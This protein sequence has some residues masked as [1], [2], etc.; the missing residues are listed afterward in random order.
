MD[1]KGLRTPGP[2]I[3]GYNALEWLPRLL[4]LQDSGELALLLKPRQYIGDGSSRALVAGMWVSPPGGHEY[5]KADPT[6]C[7]L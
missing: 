3:T 7:V 5:G 6:T 4:Q 2:T 1:V